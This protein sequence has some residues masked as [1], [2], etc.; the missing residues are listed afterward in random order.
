MELKQKLGTTF[1]IH[2]SCVLLLGWTIWTAAIEP[3]AS[4]SS[5]GMQLVVT[6]L[7]L[8]SIVLHEYGHV[9]AAAWRG[10]RTRSVVL[11]PFGGV[12]SLTADPRGPTELWIALAGPAVNV[13]IALALT[14]LIKP[15]T[16]I[17]YGPYTVLESVWLANVILPIFNMLPAYPMDGGRVLRALLTIAKVR[18]PTVIVTTLGIF[19]SVA[20]VFYALS[21]SAPLLTL[22]GLFVGFAALQE[23]KHALIVERG[24]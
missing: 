12:A 14:P 18:R 7:V 13:L 4:L 15:S 17:E 6:G 10:I 11:Y 8:V 16:I 1:R 24:T 5:I 23:R 22:V 21:H 3:G 20:M 19:L 9:A 2:P